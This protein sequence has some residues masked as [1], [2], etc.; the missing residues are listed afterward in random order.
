MGVLDMFS[1]IRNRIDLVTGMYIVSVSSKFFTHYIA[2]YFP[3]GTILDYF[4]IRGVDCKRRINNRCK[5]KLW[6]F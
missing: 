4:T 5:R 6:K 2:Q 1:Y 3:E